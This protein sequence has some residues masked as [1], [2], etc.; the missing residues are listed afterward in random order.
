MRMFAYLLVLLSAFC[1]GFELNRVQKE[2][3]KLIKSFSKLTEYMYAELSVRP[4]GIGELCW[5]AANIYEGQTKMF[6][7]AVND[8]MSNLG[9]KSFREIW[10]ECCVD[11]LSLLDK[12]ALE[13]I[14]ALGESLGNFELSAQLKA[15][16]SCSKALGK[17]Y[18]IIKEAYPNNRKLNIAVPCSVACMILMAI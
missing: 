4:C 7:V 13:I 17:E 18:Q 5:K 12:E 9:E 14:V 8:A 10:A 3:M 16:D 2:R 1:V 11:K 15:I 6:L